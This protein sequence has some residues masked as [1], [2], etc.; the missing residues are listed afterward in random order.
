MSSN[1]TICNPEDVVIRAPIDLGEEADG[2]EVQ[3][4][5]LEYIVIKKGILDK[6]NYYITKNLVERFEDGI[7]YFGFT[8]EEANQYIIHE[9]N[10]K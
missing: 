5:G 3:K 4:S 9:T 8:K 1:S 2:G 6:D 7:V 10:L